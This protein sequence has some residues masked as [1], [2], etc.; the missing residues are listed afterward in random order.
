LFGGSLG[1]GL[2]LLLRLYDVLDVFAHYTSATFLASTF[3][4]S[5]SLAAF[6]DN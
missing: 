1:N 5:L 2:I 6:P 4:S 3:D